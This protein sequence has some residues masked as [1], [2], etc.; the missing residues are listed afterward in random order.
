MKRFFKIL[1]WGVLGVV[2]LIGI[3]LLFFNFKGVPSYEVQIPD[4]LKKV[5][6]EVTPERVARGEKIA[7]VLCNGC[8]ANNEN[9]LVGKHIADLPAEFVRLTRLILPKIRKKELGLGQTEN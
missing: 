3:V 1:L 6:V 2:A 4:N 5:Q 7:L 9:R 8:H